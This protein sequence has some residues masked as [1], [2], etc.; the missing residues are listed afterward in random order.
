M[1]IFLY[2]IIQILALF[3][4]WPFVAVTIFCV[5]KY[6]GRLAGR[7]GFGLHNLR[8]PEGRRRIW[9]HALS[10]GESASAK[11]LLAAIKIA[12]PEFYII[13]TTT[14]KGGA[15]FA[16]SMAG[17]VDCLAPF[18]VDISFVVK[19]FIRHFRPDLFILI[20][21]D[22]WP[23]VLSQLRQNK[24]P[25]ILANG[26]ITE[27]SFQRYAKCRPL[28][29][30]L[31][32]S[33]DYLCMQ[34]ARDSENMVK[35][36][37]AP[38]KVTN[39][40]NLKYDMTNFPDD[41]DSRDLVFFDKLRLLA[42]RKLLVAG[43]THFGEEQI[44]LRIFKKLRRQIPGLFMVI[45]PRD[46]L[47]GK[48]VAQMSRKEG[49][50]AWTRSGVYRDSASILVLDTLGELTRIYSLADLVFI[51][52]SMVDQGG[53]NPL[54]PAFFGKPVV[55]GEYMSDFSE[56]VS[57]LLNVG[58]AETIKDEEELYKF[59]LR[60]L[61]DDTL[62]KT[63]GERGAA[64]IHQNRGAAKRYVERIVQVMRL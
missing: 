13:F 36:G 59:L 38:R 22:F 53:H 45:A 33:F 16:Q 31:F 34:T 17:L 21:T 32:E 62:R 1:L 15:Q 37:V 55:F 39:I 26:R 30:Q 25:C 24:I 50:E 56:I 52:G 47:R 48:E 63:M 64:L 28:F 5:P 58:A 29:K 46:V 7:L 10:V 57:D 9:V 60:I 3:L 2:N 27:T 54:E 41:A 11:P 40:G 35:L 23:N 51:G 19:K 44:L 14:T 8:L 18:P 49:F 20:E 42:D 43:S 6:R 12:Y 61:S 4:L